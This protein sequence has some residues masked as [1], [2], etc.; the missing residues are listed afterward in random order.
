[1]REDPHDYGLSVGNYARNARSRAPILQPSSMG[2]AEL[3]LPP[4]ERR[5]GAGIAGVGIHRNSSKIAGQYTSSAR[6]QGQ[7]D[8][9]RR[10]LF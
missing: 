9:Y 3:K 2:V 7:V 8:G 5:N 1:M 4:L 6:R 10:N